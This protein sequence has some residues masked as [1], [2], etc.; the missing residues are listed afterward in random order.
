MS[1]MHPTFA[2]K[3]LLCQNWK[4]GCKPERWLHAEPQYW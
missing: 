1:K 3:P 2:L 4:T